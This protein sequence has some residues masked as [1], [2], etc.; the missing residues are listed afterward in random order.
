MLIVADEIRKLAEESSSQGKGIAQTLKNFS[1]KIEI[2][3]N[4]SKDAER[5]FEIIFTIA[6]EVKALSSQVMAAMREQEY[7]SKEVLSAMEDINTVT[8]QVRD[9]SSEVLKGG[10]QIA[11]EMNQLDELTRVITGNMNE[12]SSGLFRINHDVQE[13]NALA[14]QNKEKSNNLT[15]E[16]SAFKV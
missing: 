5:K 9:G 8:A 11:D 14:Q 2:L 7:G 16:V 1:G 4:A 15:T 13:V 6:D 3:A 12:M 10:V